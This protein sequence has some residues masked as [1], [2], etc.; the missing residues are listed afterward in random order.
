MKLS[1]VSV[2]IIFPLHPESCDITL[3]WLMTFKIYT[4]A[5]E[6]LQIWRTRVVSSFKR[7]DLFPCLHVGLTYVCPQ[8]TIHSVYILRKI[9]WTAVKDRESSW[10]VVN[11]EHL[12]INHH[13][14]PKLS[15]LLSRAGVTL[16]GCL[17]DVFWQLTWVLSDIFHSRF[18]VF[19]VVSRF[20]RHTQCTSTH[21][22]TCKT[23]EHLH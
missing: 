3:N 20:N 4:I 21:A 19:V 8:F 18:C 14:L 7:S 12:I 16:R 10:D 9:L 22:R 2:N 6:R 15:W 17:R 5:M 13:F 1:V 23:N 11:I